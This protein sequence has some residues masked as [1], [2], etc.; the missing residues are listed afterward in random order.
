MCGGT[1]EIVPCSHVGHVFRSRSPFTWTKGQALSRN[2]ARL[3]EVWMDDFKF[4]YYERSTKKLVSVLPKTVLSLVGLFMK[5]TCADLE[6][7]VRGVLTTFL[8]PHSGSAQERISHVKVSKVAKIRNRYNQVPHLTQDTN[9][10]V[11]NSQ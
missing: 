5:P 2:L 1:L 7:S 8:F 6:K 9:G 4:Y 10:K 11:T 3:A